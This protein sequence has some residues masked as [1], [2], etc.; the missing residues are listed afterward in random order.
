M[1]EFND[2]SLLTYQTLFCQANGG[3]FQP[4]QPFACDNVGQRNKIEG[5]TLEAYLIRKIVIEIVH[6]INTN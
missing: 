4:L 3:K 2:T 1:K 6:C 5:I